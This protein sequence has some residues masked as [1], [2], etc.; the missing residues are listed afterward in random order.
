MSVDQQAIFELVRT[1]K[2]Q[3]TP[4]IVVGDQVMIGSRSPEKLTDWAHEN[5]ANTG[6][7]EETARFGELLAIATLGTATEEALK[8]AGSKNFDGKVLIDATNP[9]HFEPGRP[10]S[11]AIGGNDSLGEHVQRTVPSARVVKAFNTVGNAHFVDPQFPGG[12]PDMFICGNDASAKETVAGICTTFGWPQPIDLGGIESA[13]YLE[14]LA[15]VWIL[16]YF[17]TRSGN[18]AFKLLRK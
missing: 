9:L 14:A 3:S 18:H 7:F 13:R 12:P 8:L 5:G 4:T 6:T 16:T 17:A 15:M 11:L 1:Y 2:S 10:P